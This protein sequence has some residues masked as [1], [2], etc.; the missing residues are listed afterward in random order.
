ME[1]EM[2]SIPGPA[3]WPQLHELRAVS[4]DGEGQVRAAISVIRGDP[5]GPRIWSSARGSGIVKVDDIVQ[6]PIASSA[7]RRNAE[8][9]PCGN[10][11][12][13]AGCRCGCE[14]PRIAHRRARYY[15]HHCLLEDL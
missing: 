9:T 4:R 1:D 10:R 15:A 5:C 6:I 3:Q 14:V 11:S 8:A 13:W 7:Q 12:A 2:V